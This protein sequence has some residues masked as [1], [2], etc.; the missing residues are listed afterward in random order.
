MIRKIKFASANRRPFSDM[1]TFQKKTLITMLPDFKIVAL[2]I[3]DINYADEQK[4]KTK[5]N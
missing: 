3:S 2:F 1:N 5:N 4:V